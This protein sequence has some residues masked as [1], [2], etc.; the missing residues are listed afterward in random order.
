[1]KRASFID[2]VGNALV[3]EMELVK[4]IF[5][6]GTTALDQYITS[7]IPKLASRLPNNNELAEITRRFMPEV[8]D[9]MA[10]LNIALRMWAGYMDAAKTIA[11][12]T[13][14]GP[15]T[16]QSRQQN[17][18]MIEPRAEQD[19]IYAAGIVAAPSLKRRKKGESII[20]DGIPTGSI[21]LID[22]DDGRTG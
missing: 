20:Q 19:P 22:W 17:M 13:A 9:F 12:T 2:A 6:Q 5:P 7:L 4:K 11:E 8:S 15:N 3:A 21:I 1:M 14:D 16:S 18:A 10:R